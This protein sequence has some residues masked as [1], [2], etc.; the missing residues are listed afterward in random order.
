MTVLTGAIKRKELAEAMRWA[1][2]NIK[3][4]ASKW[5]ELNP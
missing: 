1:T 2:I 4:L 5:R 3:T